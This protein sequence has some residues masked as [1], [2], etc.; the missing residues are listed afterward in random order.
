MAMQGE[1][2]IQSC[3]HC[4]CNAQSNGREAVTAVAQTAGLCLVLAA[5]NITDANL[6]WEASQGAGQGAHLIPSQLPV[7]DEG[8]RLAVMGQHAAVLVHRGLGAEAPDQA[9]P[10]LL[11]LR[12]HSDHSVHQVLGIR[13]HKATAFKVASADQGSPGRSR[14][15]APKPELAES[16]QEITSAGPGFCQSTQGTHDAPALWSWHACLAAVWHG[17]ARGASPAAPPPAHCTAAEPHACPTSADDRCSPSPGRST[18]LPPAAW[19]YS[20]AMHAE[21]SPRPADR[22]VDM[23]GL[24]SAE[25]AGVTMRHQRGARALHRKCS[26]CPASC[27]E[28]P[29]KSR[30]AARSRTALGLSGG[31]WPRLMSN[32]SGMIH[33]TPDKQHQIFSLALLAKP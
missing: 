30:P 28:R 25:T 31:D 18:S 20:Q 6:I 19:L 16:S 5:P 2:L 24:P 14:C 21:A 32:F 12:Q 27:F 15:F 23:H 10:P 13:L 22:W 1:E 9:L 17:T 29:R 3:G 33:W 26:T 4:T 7:I 8:Q 11:H